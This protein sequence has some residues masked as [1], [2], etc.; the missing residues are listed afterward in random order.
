[1]CDEDSQKAFLSIHHER[2]VE[3]MSKKNQKS[4]PSRPKIPKLSQVSNERDLQFVLIVCQPTVN[5]DVVQVPV[6]SRKVSM[7]APH[8]NYSSIRVT[9]R[10]IAQETD[11]L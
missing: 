3:D 10:N 6:K 5:V 9:K 8:N 2:I 4:I 1:M 11:K 7:L